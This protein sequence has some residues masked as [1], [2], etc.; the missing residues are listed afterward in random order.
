MRCHT[1]CFDCICAGANDA[2]AAVDSRLEPGHT[3]APIRAAGACLEVG[4]IHG[5]NGGEKEENGGLELHY[6]ERLGMGS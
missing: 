5:G 2:V 6:G 1:L 3:C 4:R